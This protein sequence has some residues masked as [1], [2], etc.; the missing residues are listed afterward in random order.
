MLA[1]QN[2]EQGEKE[3]QFE[4]GGIREWGE[5][6]KDEDQQNNGLKHLDGWMGRTK[7]SDKN[8]YYEAEQLF[9]AE[10]LKW[11]V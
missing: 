11:K 5:Q 10:S 9:R 1:L 2:K 3:Y 4:N 8:C 6:N 7:S